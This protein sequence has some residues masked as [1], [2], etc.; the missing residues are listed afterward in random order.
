MDKS[1][2]TAIIDKMMENDWYSQWL[3]VKRI[4]EGPGFCILEMVVRKEMLNGF[5]ILHGGVSFAFADSAFAFASNS[6]GQKSVSIETSISHFS[7]AKEG[8][9]LRTKVI[10][11]HVSNKIGTYIIEINNQN[12]KMIALFKGTVYRTSKVWEV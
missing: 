12:S 10:E 5:G 8:D 3:Q 11:Q 4:D 6:R 2:A 1:Q 9:I 7:Q